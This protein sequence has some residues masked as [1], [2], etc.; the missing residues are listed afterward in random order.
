[1][2]IGVLWPVPHKEEQTKGICMAMLQF[3]A[4][5]NELKGN[6]RIQDGKHMTGLC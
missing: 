2:G 6:N 1:M 3:V 4:Y 5:C